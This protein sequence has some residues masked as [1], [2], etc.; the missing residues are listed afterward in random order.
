MALARVEAKMKDIEVQLKQIEVKL[1]T[2]NTDAR[3][4]EFLPTVTMYTPN[5]GDVT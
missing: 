3:G 2:N 4:T 5:P 1:E